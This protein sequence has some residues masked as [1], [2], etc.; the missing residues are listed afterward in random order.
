MSDVQTAV[1]REARFLSPHVRELTLE[2]AP[3][4][5]APG[6]W[7][8]LRLPI[9][10]KPPLVRAYSLANAP[11]V[12]GTLTLCFDHVEGGLGSQYLW[13]VEPGTHLEF[14]GPLGNFTLAGTTGNLIF[15]ARYTGVVPFRAVLESLRTETDRRVLLV[16]GCPSDHEAIYRDELRSWEQVTPGLTCRFV[17][18]TD[19]DTLPELEA[20]ADA[21]DFA[22]FT[23]YVCGVRE[24]TLPLRNFLMERFG[25][26]RRQVKVENYNGPSGR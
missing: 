24:F 21:A 8:S 10:D 2:A 20:L 23:P 18:L 16:C 7:L 25:F 26:E 15:A 1:V 5:F 22:P 14:T 11:R 12:D 3:F 9:G 13:S 6:Q 17:N 4:A 19:S